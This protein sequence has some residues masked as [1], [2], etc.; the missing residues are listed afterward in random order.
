MFNFGSM[1]LKSALSGFI[2]G[3]KGKRS[4]YGSD[5][6]YP[7]SYY[8]GENYAKEA[9]TVTTASKI[10]TVYTCINTISQD[11]AKLPFNVMKDSKT[12]GRQVQK[13]NPVYKLIHTAPNDS[14]TAYNFWYAMMWNV[15]SRGNGYAIIIRDESHQ[16][17]SLI[18][19]RTLD[20]TILCEGLDIFYRIN[21]QI[22]PYTDVI[23]LKVNSVDCIT[24]ISPI[25]WN[26]NLMGYKIKQE[27]YSAQ[28]IGT[29][30]TGF[31]TSE[32]LDAKQGQMIADQYKEALNQGKTPFLG[33]QGSTK[34]QNQMIT[35]NEAQYIE[36]KYQTNTEIYGI[37][38]LPPAF[39]QNYEKATYSNAAQQ[40]QVYVKHTLTPYIKMIEQ[41][42]DSKLFTE[43]NSNRSNPLFTNFNVNGILRGDIE[44]RF[45][46]YHDMILD[47]VYTADEVR[48]FENMPP[49]PDGLGKDPYIQGA[50]VKKGTEPIDSDPNSNRS[51]NGHEKEI[52][53]ILQ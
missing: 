35:P 18:Q 25:M 22:Y 11:I 4:Y 9:V 6:Y 21:G 20:V 23:H 8:V 51:M 40:D 27:R 50:M 49:Q 16:P 26:A 38:R 48:K 14:T 30:G 7:G 33:T 13:N 53:K 32:G 5:G 36:T 34:W 2:N 15:L 37:F 31:I 17:I 19:A 1:G 52:Q 47:G 43:A 3:L 42:C 45:K 24:G 28:A 44:T 46:T 29:K 12:E 41:E 10:S 39:A